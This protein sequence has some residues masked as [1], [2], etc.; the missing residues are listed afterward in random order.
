MR[1]RQFITLIGGAAAWPFVA[2]AQVTRKHPLIGR[3][4]F[5][6]RDTPLI[7]RYINGFLSGMRELGYVE[8]RDFDMTYAMADFHA[9]RLPQVTAEL[10]KLAPDVIVAGAT[11]EAV[12]AAKATATIPI[13]VGALAEPV[14]LGFATSDARPTGNV[15][16]IMPYVKGLP[17]KQLE[18]AREVV[19]GATRIGLVDDVTD[20]KA[21]PQRQEIEAA[22]RS[23][24]IEIVPAEVRTAADIDAAYQALAS[25]GVR[26]V[27][28][29]QSNMLVNASKTIA[30][31]AASKRLP[32]VYGYREHVEAGG[33]VSYGINLDWCQ[34]REAYYVDKILKGTNPS[35]L[36][37]EFPTNVELVINLKTA[38]AL[39]ITVPSSLLVRADEAIE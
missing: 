22:G 39:G 35:D 25:A 26:V 32:T 28:V 8:G 15:T 36:P 21:H 14:A 10:V 37:I 33:L 34:H 30:E 4:S 19:P 12:A 9:D 5:G 11:L 2:R 24:E 7:V 3:L 1:R 27:V 20:P 38:K 16:G 18:L 17:A 23:L 6:S 29:E 13:V 31:A